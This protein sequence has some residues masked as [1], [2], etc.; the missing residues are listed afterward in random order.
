MSQSSTSARYTPSAFRSCAGTSSKRN[1]SKKLYQSSCVMHN[2][3][4][5]MRECPYGV[6]QHPGRSAD[7]REK[8]GLPLRSGF[9]LPFPFMRILYQKNAQRARVLEGATVDL[10]K[11]TQKGIVNRLLTSYQLF[12]TANSD[13]AFGRPRKKKRSVC[14]F[15]THHLYF[16]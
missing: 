16:Y 8:N 10:C 9:H 11:K 1:T 6:R 12:I 7:A 14:T 13:T 3:L 4:L 15:A 2:R 5:L